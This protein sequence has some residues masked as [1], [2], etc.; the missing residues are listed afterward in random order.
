MAFDRLGID[1]Q[2]GELAQQRAALGEADAGG[3]ESGHAQRRRRQ[4]G[5]LQAERA[6]ARRET[7]VAVVAVIPGAPQ[8]HLAQCRGE[9]LCPAARVAGPG[10]AV[11]RLAGTRLVG[12]VG[13]QAR[14][15]RPT[16]DRKRHAPRRSL[17]GLEVDRPGRPRADQPVRLGRDLRRDDGFERPLF[18]ACRR[19]PPSVS[20][21]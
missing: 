12:A 2:P 18:P 7:A 17:H 4:R 5:P 10:A 21:A 1:V 8:R 3:G 20:R 11:A 19:S 14:G 6:V 13:V 9:G 15:H 16:H